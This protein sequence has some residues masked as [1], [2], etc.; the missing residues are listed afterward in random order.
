MNTYRFR[1][2]RLHPRLWSPKYRFQTTF[3]IFHIEALPKLVYRHNNYATRHLRE[4]TTINSRIRSPKTRNLT[5]TRVHLKINLPFRNAL[6]TS[7]IHLLSLYY[8]VG[9]SECFD[10][11]TIYVI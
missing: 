9:G 4:K 2:S 11:K 1:T 5:L 7:I 6:V 8:Y 3:K 10:N